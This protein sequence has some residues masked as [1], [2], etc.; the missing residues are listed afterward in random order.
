MVGGNATPGL[1]TGSEPVDPMVVA[2]NLC[3]PPSGFN[4]VP[5]RHY[6]ELKAKKVL[7]WLW[8]QVRAWVAGVV[9]VA[10]RNCVSPPG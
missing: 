5:L 7:T 8:L 3:T 10:S 4:L 6:P 2:P 9:M 1:G